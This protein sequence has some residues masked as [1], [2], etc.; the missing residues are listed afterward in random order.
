MNPTA[1]KRTGGQHHSPCLVAPAIRGLHARHPLTR[2]EQPRHRSLRKRDPRNRLQ[3][4][5]HRATIQPAI[6][7][8]ARAP[9]RR[10]LGAVEHP[11]LDPRAVGSPPHDPTQRVH[12]PRHR[13]LGYPANGRVARHLPDHLEILGQQQHPR[14]SPGRKGASLGAG[15][16]AA[17]YNHVMGHG[18]NVA[19]REK[20]EARSNSPTGWNASIQARAPEP[21]SQGQAPSGSAQQEPVH[22]PMR[23]PTGRPPQLLIRRQY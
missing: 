1:Q 3:Q 8:G 7:L 4:R 5:P 2:D 11:E 18:C 9:D 10:T 16:A 21:P 15:V 20:R 19:R 13:P 6:A 23:P 14:A 17:D 12:L 22:K